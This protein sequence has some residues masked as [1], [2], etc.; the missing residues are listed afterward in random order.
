MDAAS[1]NRLLG[2]GSDLQTSSLQSLLSDCVAQAREIVLF[3]AEPSPTSLQSL[4]SAATELINGRNSGEG[5]ASLESTTLQ[6]A[7]VMRDRAQDLRS[8]LSAGSD[9]VAATEAFM[10]AASAFLWTPE[11]T[12][13][14][15]ARPALSLHEASTPQDFRPE[16][17]GDR[18]VQ[19]DLVPVAYREFTPAMQRLT[20]LLA[21]KRADFD[22][23]VVTGRSGVALGVFLEHAGIPATE[24]PPLRHHSGVDAENRPKLPVSIEVLCEQISGKRV[25]FVDDQIGGSTTL[26]Y[27]R[28][29]TSA[30]GGT[31]AGVA[32]YRSKFAGE[33]CRFLMPSE[34]DFESG[35]PGTSSGEIFRVLPDLEAV[36][37]AQGLRSPF[38][39]G[40]SRESQ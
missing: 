14:Q 1:D 29:A 16:I 5:V 24:L 33:S 7:T 34:R 36:F 3:S 31:F 23:C 2:Q 17:T 39:G 25:L 30:L 8:Q 35:L 32:M 40:R 6:A 37:S 9:V 19:L 12:S 18:A 38:E 4:A 11:A 21:A 13:I 15:V 22:V 26:H 10:Q 20:D 28:L 27:A